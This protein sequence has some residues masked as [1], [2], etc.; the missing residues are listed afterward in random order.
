MWCTAGS[1]GR[2]EKGK[3]KKLERGRERERGKRGETLKTKAAREHDSAEV[4]ERPR[5]PVAAAETKSALACAPFFFFW[6]T[7]RGF[8]PPGEDERVTVSSERELLRLQ[9][10]WSR[11]STT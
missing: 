10:A 2:S 6:R 7:V 11:N 1:A 4:R 8:L 5:I 3:K 9:T